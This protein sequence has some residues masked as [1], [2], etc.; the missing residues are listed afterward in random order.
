MPAGKSVVLNVL[1]ST[2]KVLRDKGEEAFDF[3][4]NLAERTNR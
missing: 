3:F 2:K 4:L 1:Q